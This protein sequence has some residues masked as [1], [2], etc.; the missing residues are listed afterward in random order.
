MG[1][2]SRRSP[3]LDPRP[4]R[5]FSFPARDEP[6]PVA[7]SHVGDGVE[8]SYPRQ[9]KLVAG[10]EQ[11]S[12]LGAHAVSDGVQPPRIERE[13]GEGLLRERG[14]P[15]KILD[16]SREPPRVE[17][18]PSSLPIGRDQREPSPR[19]QRAPESEV[20]R[21]VDAPSVRRD[22]QRDRRMVACS[23][24]GGNDEVCPALDS[25][26][27]KPG[28]DAAVVNAELVGNLDRAHPPVDIHP[29]DTVL[30]D[31]GNLICERRVV[32][33]A[34]GIGH[35]EQLAVSVLMLQPLAGERRPPGGP[36]EQKAA[37][38]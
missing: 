36:A 23:I 32:R 17:R 29:A 20:V 21:A 33:D 24:P 15:R 1:H 16:L 13:P 27:F 31:D 37:R 11:Q 30:D 6:I 25:R 18:Q 14:H 10:D 34:V 7:N 26:P 9:P 35:R 12:L 38:A 28:V 8:S 4:G 2:S 3:E 22:H 5:K 19:G